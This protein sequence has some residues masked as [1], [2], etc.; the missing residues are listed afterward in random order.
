MFPLASS[1]QTLSGHGMDVRPPIYIVCVR[2]KL[3]LFESVPS[4]STQCYGTV[5]KRL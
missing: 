4:H 3:Y 1:A 5:Y 2:Q